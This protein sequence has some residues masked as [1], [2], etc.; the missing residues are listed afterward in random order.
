M[1]K[2]L[3]A[4][5]CIT[6][7]ATA[8]TSCKKD[9]PVP[10]NSITDVLLKTDRFSTLKK[11]VT[12]VGLGPTLTTGT[13]TVFGPNDVAF[14]AAGINNFSIESILPSNLSPVL[15]YHTIPSRILSSAIPNAT[16]TKVITASGDS[17][18]VSKNSRGI[19]VN[20][21]QVIAADISADNGVIHELGKVLTKPT[22]NI[23]QKAI[24]AKLDSLVKAITLVNGSPMGNPGLINLLST[25]SLT[26]FAPTN[27]AFTE[28]LQTLNLPAIEQIPIA[29]LNAVLSYHLVGS[30]AFASDLSSGA[31]SMFAGG[32]TTVALS[33]LA[34]IRGN[35]NGGTPSNITATD[36]ICTNGVVH[37]IDRVLLP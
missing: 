7:A 35:G 26:V 31:L 22:E 4:L 33:S 30:R 34:T 2:S 14:N 27:A 3:L 24:S 13:Y 5:A 18:F 17:V 19:F 16:N 21:V 15:L 36:I 12:K 37:L 20:G 1:K 23:V 29:T 25:S 28:L 9:E 32:N 10:T 6:L 8:I 11:A